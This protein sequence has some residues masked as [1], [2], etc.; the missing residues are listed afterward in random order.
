M[1]TQL[2]VGVMKDY[3]KRF[4]NEAYQL[5]QN[6][7]FDES[8]ASLDPLLS[9]DMKSLLFKQEKLFAVKEKNKRR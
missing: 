2:L 1:N 9:A 6:T 3:C 4:R 8:C 5:S 7:V